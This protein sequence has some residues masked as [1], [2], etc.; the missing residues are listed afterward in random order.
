MKR[1]ESA[2][3]LLKN[4]QNSLRP[5]DGLTDVRYI[6]RDCADAYLPEYP[7]ELW[8]KM[9]QPLMYSLDDNVVWIRF[10]IVIPQKIMGIPVAG[11]SVRLRSMFQAPVEFYIDGALRMKENTWIDFQI[12]EL[13]LTDNAEADTVYRC[14]MRIDSA[15]ANWGGT[16]NC[17][18]E[19]N[20]VDS[21]HFDIG[22]LQ[23]ELRYAFTLPG[24]E[25]VAGRVLD[26]LIPA[27]QKLFESNDLSLLPKVIAKAREL[28]EPLRDAAKAHK[29][30][31]IAHA[32]IDMNWLWDMQETCDIIKRDFSTVCKLMDEFPDLCFSQS[33]SA[34]YKI[35][36]EHYPDIF[37]SLKHNVKRGNWD[38]TA[39][40][41][42]ENDADMPSGESLARHILYSQQ[43]LKDELDVKPKL[44]WAPDTFGHCGNLP[45]LLNK[46]GITRYFHSR[47]SP[48]NLDD[49]LK[50]SIDRLYVWEGIDGSRVLSATMNYNG[51]IDIADILRKVSFSVRAGLTDTLCVFGVGDHGGGPTR[52]HIQSILRCN[53]SPML[54]QLIMDTTDNY[55]S[56]VEQQTNAV[57]KLKVHKG[58]V[59]FIFE[60]CYTSHSDIKKANREV[61]TLLYDT[62]VLC[63][64][65]KKYGLD[66]PTETINECWETLLFNQFHD[67]LDGCAVE[68][69]YREA[70]YHMNCVK[71]KLKDMQLKALS[72]I[73][74]PKD[75]HISFY[76]TLPYTRSELVTMNI[77]NDLSPFDEYGNPIPEQKCAD[78]SRIVYLKD[79][80]PFG[81]KTVI[82]N[83]SKASFPKG[84]IEENDK[85]YIIDGPHYYVWIK[86]SSGEIITFYDKHSK[87]FLVRAGVRSSRPDMG[88][89][90]TFSITKEHPDLH[91]SAWAFDQPKSMDYLKD[92]AVCNIIEDGELCKVIQFRHHYGASW[93][94]QNIIFDFTSPLIRFETEVDWHEIGSPKTETPMLRVGFTPHITCDGIINEVPFGATKRD[95]IDWEYPQWRWSAVEYSEGG[96]I[97][98]N[99]CKYGIHS[100]GNN[101]ELSLIR[102]SS[103]PDAHA[104]IGK[105]S[106]TYAIAAY[107]GT[108]SNTP[109]I[110]QAAALHSPLIMTEGVSL[111]KSSDINLDLPYQLVLSGAKKCEFSDALIVRIYEP[112][113]CPAKF[114]L[115]LPKDIKSVEE[116]ETNEQE[117]LMGFMIENNSCNIS[118]KPYEIKTLR[119]SF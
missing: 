41:W 52:R 63:L 37:K 21:L 97:L 8:A 71:D 17:Y 65:A 66:Y 84:S 36:N 29:V 9:E 88:I 94:T 60:G 32:H 112:F 119:L 109:V 18:V 113:G 64:L 47:C 25:A 48:E 2:I 6:K 30:H 73:S 83:K 57:K 12:P 49:Y 101:M 5:S 58:E 87:R 59:N 38:V 40:A 103:E 53:L 45:Q 33:Q 100:T 62:E 51:I 27:A 77:P 70:I 96:L 55:F 110:K 89:M 90:N 102:S 85:A 104:D 118:F 107:Q 16:F 115:P 98:F 108:I 86:K 11:H 80:P 14:A 15:N 105:H 92:G 31:L 13:V 44:M 106:F 42:V 81:S 22:C 23:E 116:V 10:K 54:P 39:S 4:I 117:T 1:L 43:Y 46:S 82:L 93:L 72:H 35:C 76:N 7:D 28:A 79:I 99:T 50:P 19:Y 91:M 26:Y 114:S 74:E 34:T 20:L 24:A 3:S 111:I 78:T 69:S 68:A 95:N 61:E 67:I 56:A 75:N